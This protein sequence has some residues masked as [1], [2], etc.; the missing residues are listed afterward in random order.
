LAPCLLA[1]FTDALLCVATPS[2]G[3]LRKLVRQSMP[4]SFDSGHIIDEL[5]Y[6]SR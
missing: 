1:L 4:T 5:P 2:I 3:K 6:L